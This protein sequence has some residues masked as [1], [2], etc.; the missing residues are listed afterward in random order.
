MDPSID[1][2][3][4][5]LGQPRGHR[6]VRQCLAL[7]FV[8]VSAVVTISAILTFR[9]S[10]ELSAH[11]SEEAA[12]RGFPYVDILRQRDHLEGKIIF[13]WHKRWATAMH[14]WSELPAGKPAAVIA[15]ANEHD[16][17]L[18]MGLVNR[19][20]VPLTV[21][22][23]GHSL[24]AYSVP[25]AGSTGNGI[26]LWTKDMDTNKVVVDA[27]GVVTVGPAVSLL[28]VM[29]ALAPKGLFVV[30][31][32]CANV[33]VGGYV[34]GGGMGLSH[35]LYGFASDDLLSARV[36]LAN[37]TRVVAS[38]ESNPDLF[39]AL[40][41]RGAGNW[42][43]VTSYDI[44]AHPE[45]DMQVFASFR[46]A[47]KDLA[48]LMVWMADE[49]ADGGVIPRNLHCS[50]EGGMGDAEGS[51]AMFAY[52][53]RE[54]EPDGQKFF[55]S[56]LLP[57][58]PV[59]YTNFTLTKQSRTDWENAQDR[60]EGFMYKCMDGFA[61]APDAKTSIPA[62][63]EVI[64]EILKTHPDE[65]NAVFFMMG[66][67]IHDMAPEDTA[68][69]WRDAVWDLA[70]CSGVATDSPNADETFAEI[71]GSMS[72]AFVG[73]RQYLQ[74]SYLNWLG[75]SPEEDYM[76]IYYGSNAGRLMS[77]K[78]SVDPRNLFKFPQSVPL[79]HSRAD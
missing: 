38:S 77:I 54:G 57:S 25:A 33:A 8:L 23:G 72:K 60:E 52:I 5:L 22:S 11:D 43:V 34:Q 36:V 24:R 74:G 19:L 17:S 64:L 61:T 63:T 53:A 40:R 42:G 47:N 3:T 48:Q 16:V 50:I 62:A 31:G 55:S 39:W 79:G 41:S 45:P 35:R 58:L 18:V 44:Q 71:Y 76:S 10:E 14:T 26:T 7:S 51:S 12:E 73:A 9:S 67:A 1:Y 69:P 70:I 15:A 20:Q 32:T 66:G 56:V 29:D 2:Q 37:G 59:P 49:M 28:D 78:A 4:P 68:F 30:S 13:P 46:V 75:T 21:K 65:L 27:K 6:R